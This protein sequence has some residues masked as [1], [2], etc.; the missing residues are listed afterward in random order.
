LDECISKS[1]DEIAIQ[2]LKFTK[3]ELEKQIREEIY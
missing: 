1:D 3:K 2:N